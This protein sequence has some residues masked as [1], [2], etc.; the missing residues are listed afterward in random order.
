MLHKRARLSAT[1]VAEVLQK[2]RGQRAQILSL[3]FQATSAPFKC[4]VVVSKKVARSAVTRNSL[5]RAVYRALRET[6]LPATGRA[7]L[8]VQSVPPENRAAIFA[9]DIKKLLHV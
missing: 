9:S 4:A 3:K 7:I 6:S 2:G 1:E 5:R 8:F